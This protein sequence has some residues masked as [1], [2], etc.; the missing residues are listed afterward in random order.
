MRASMVDCN[1]D[2]IEYDNKQRDLDIKT[3][4]SGGG[5]MG[6]APMRVQRFGLSKCGVAHHSSLMTF[7]CVPIFVQCWLQAL[8]A[9]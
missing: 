2:G 6:D 4:S 9:C 5:D 3:R 1:R 8:R 7:D